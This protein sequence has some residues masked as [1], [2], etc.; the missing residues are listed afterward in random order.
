MQLATKHSY[1]E[2]QIKLLLKNGA[3]TLSDEYEFSALYYAIERANLDVVR[4]IF[5]NT[6]QKIIYKNNN[7][8]FVA[9]YYRTE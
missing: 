7:Y 6:P 4:L 5:K 1:S 2:K 3:N 9:A 8:N